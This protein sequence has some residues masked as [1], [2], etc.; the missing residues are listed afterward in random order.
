MIDLAMDALSARLSRRGTADRGVS[1]RRRRH[2]MIPGAE[3]LEVRDCPSGPG[4]QTGV[5]RPVPWLASIAQATPQTPQVRLISRESP[6]EH[7]MALNRVRKRGAQ[8]IY[9][10]TRGRSNARAGK[11]PSRPLGSLAVALK[12]ARSGATIILAPGVYTEN[13]AVVGKSNITMIGA[14]NNGSILAPPSGQALKIYSSSNITIQNIWFRSTAGIGLAIVGSSVEVSNIKTDGTYGD[15]VAVADYAGRPGFL[16][17]TS[18]QFNGSQMGDGLH[19]ESNGAGSSATI[20]DS[21]FNGNGTSPNAGQ[22]SNGLVLDPGTSVNV[23]NSQ[24]SSNTNAG[25]TASGN[26]QVT[27]SGSTFNGNVKGDGAIFFGQT[28]VTLT[29][30]T[31]ASN[32]QVVDTQKGLDGVEFFAGPGSPDTYTGTAVVSGNSFLNNT[33]FGIYAGSAGQLTISDNQ[34]SGN[35]FGIYL[36][37]TLASINATVVGNTIAVG[38]ETEPMPKGIVAVGTGVVATIGGS[39]GQANTIQDYPGGLYILEAMGKGSPK[40]GFPNLNI[41]TNNYLSNGSPVDPSRAISQFNQ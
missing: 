27:V 25:L 3:S 39:G 6:A 34:F 8:T 33:A 9:V 11:T 31:F 38:S 35:I 29:G 20:T 30:N 40:A 14:A 36:D 17:A 19:L 22:I 1:H 23:T 4:V 32:G 24:F 18:S 26:A 2:R 16:N 12:R 5:E 28:T 10:A 7:Q 41:L 37:G 15:G 13:G 21:T